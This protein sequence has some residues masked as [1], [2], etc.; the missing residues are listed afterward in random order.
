MKNT[1]IPLLLIGILLSASFGLAKMNHMDN[2]GG[3]V[4]CPFETARVTD[5][6]R[7]QT[8]INSVTSHL[9][10]LSKFLSTIPVNGFDGLIS[11]FLIFALTIFV[12]FNKEFE[13]F[14][15]NPLFVK[16]N[17]RKAFVSSNKIL[18]AHWLALHENS[19]S[20]MSGR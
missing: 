10:A 15:L 4:Q 14:R 1:L 11:I 9:S 7:L 8:P 19:P 6:T 2:Q 5:C 13:L 3:H 18:L 20:F 17:L 16:S 12:T